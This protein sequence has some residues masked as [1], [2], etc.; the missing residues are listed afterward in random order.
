MPVAGINV[1]LRHGMEGRP[2]KLKE[3]VVWI[4]LVCVMLDETTLSRSFQKGKVDLLRA[5]SGRTARVVTRPIRNLEI[6]ESVA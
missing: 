3:G 5:R 6:T 4:G 2:L 1:G